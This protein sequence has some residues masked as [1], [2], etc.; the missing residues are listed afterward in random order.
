MVGFRRRDLKSQSVGT[1][2]FD[3]IRSNR[4]L[5]KLIG[6][7]PVRPECLL[8]GSRPP[9]ITRLCCSYFSR[10]VPD[11]GGD[12][13]TDVRVVGRRRRGLLSTTF[14]RADRLIRRRRLGTPEGW[15]TLETFGLMAPLSVILVTA[16]IGA[17]SLAGEESRRTMGFDGQPAKPFQDVIEKTVTRCCSE[18]RW[19]RTF[20]GVSLGRYW[21][22][23]AC[24]LAIWLPRPRFRCW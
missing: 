19:R 4:L 20:A 1:S 16:V 17:G 11:H 12:F 14:R 10:Y 24:Q 18:R 7:L 2:L 22:I 6:H 13:G 15:Y 8:F 9:R 3:R 5:N 23:S 21:A